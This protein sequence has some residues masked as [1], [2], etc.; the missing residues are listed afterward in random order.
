LEE[1]EEVAVAEAVRAEDRAEDRADAPVAA[2]FGGAR[3]APFA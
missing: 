3:S 1:E 2:L